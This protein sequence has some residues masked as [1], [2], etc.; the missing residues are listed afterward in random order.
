MLLVNSYL[1]PKYTPLPHH[2]YKTLWSIDYA[3]TTALGFRN[4]I[5]VEVLLSLAILNKMSDTHFD[6]LQKINMLW[7]LKRYYTLITAF[8]SMI[9]IAYVNE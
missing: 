5:P 9:L 1:I 3:K 8:Y 4:L 6:Q 7:G 2:L